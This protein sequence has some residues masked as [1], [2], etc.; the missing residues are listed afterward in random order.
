MSTQKLNST[1]IK[2][3]FETLFEQ[4]PE[5][6]VDHRAHMLSFLFLSEADKAME[7]KGWTRKQL[8]KEI[9]TSASYLTQLFRGDR[10]LNLKTVAKI[11][12]ALSL[13]FQISESTNRKQQKEYA[14]FFVT[15]DE[16]QISTKKVSSPYYDKKAYKSYS[17]CN[18]HELRAA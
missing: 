13:E 14:Q 17:G 8:A 15:Q 16:K 3:K 9:G 2:D 6:K 7:S 4:S 18:I 1:S 11:E 10:L 12:M 5:E